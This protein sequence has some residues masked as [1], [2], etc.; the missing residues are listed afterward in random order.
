MLVVMMQR[1]SLVAALVIGAGCSA[2]TSHCSLDQQCGP[3]MVC[4]ADQCIVPCSDDRV[5]G[6]EAVCKDGECLTGCRVH[7]DCP[8]GR[9]CQESACV[10]GCVGRDRC[11]AYQYCSDQ[12]QCLNGCSRDG[13]C[14]A[15][16][17]CED[18]KCIPIGDSTDAGPPLCTNHESCRAGEF[19]APDGRCRV[20]C[21]PGTCPRGQTCDEQTGRCSGWQ[22]PA[23]DAGTPADTG[24]NQD[25]GPAIAFDVQ[26]RL[27]FNEVVTSDLQVR[28]DGQAIIELMPEFDATIEWALVASPDDSGSV[29]WGEVQGRNQPV[30]LLRVGAYTLRATATYRGVSES[31]DLEVAGRPPE[32]GYWIELGWNGD[33]DLDLHLVPLPNEERCLNDSE[34]EQNQLRRRECNQEFCSRSFNS[35]DGRDGDCWARNANPLWSDPNDEHTNPHYLG[36]VRS[37]SGT[38]NIS[39]GVINDG[40]ALRVGLRAWAEVTNLARLKIYKDGRLVTETDALRIAPESPASWLYL[41]RLSSR[42]YTPVLQLSADAPRN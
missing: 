12:G 21:R 20:G 30:A 25:A 1:L 33:R 34:C 9:V 36:D 2:E 19:C 38:E 27:L 23:T 7:P 17:F 42:G 28:A 13:D 24:Q 26:C 16:Q 22:P 14:G 10:N 29:I 35:R 15:G 3:H 32:R 4:R 40:W 31:C 11:A 37:G 18:N 39:V 41:G 6:A 8:L 5:C